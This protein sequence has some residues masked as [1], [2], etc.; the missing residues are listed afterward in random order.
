[1][2]YGIYGVCLR[3]PTF[4]YLLVRNYTFSL[5]WPNVRI[6]KPVFRQCDWGFRERVMTVFIITF[7][8]GL[9]TQKQVDDKCNTIRDC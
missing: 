6:R 4:L 8:S 5:A 2:A 3:D 7:D 9:V 1:M